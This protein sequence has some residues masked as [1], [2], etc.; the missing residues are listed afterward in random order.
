[1]PVIAWGGVRSLADLA[2]GITEGHASAVLAASI[3]HFG[4]HS[5]MEAKDYMRRAGIAMRLDQ[6]PAGA[7]A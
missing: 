2:A 5:V 4:Q 1:V 7:E 3:F 6:A